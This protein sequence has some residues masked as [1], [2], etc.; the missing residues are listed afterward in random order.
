[1]V[2]IPSFR[3]VSIMIFPSDLRKTLITSYIHLHLFRPN[4]YARSPST[5]LLPRQGFGL[6]RC[7]RI[8]HKIPRRQRVPFGAVSRVLRS[9]GFTI[10]PVLG[11]NWHHAMRF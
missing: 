10:T 4:F 3:L 9:D 11:R 6:E 2:R 7:I 5:E 1:M 8:L